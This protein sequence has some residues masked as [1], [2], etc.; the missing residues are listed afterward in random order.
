MK[1]LKLI[2]ELLKLMSNPIIRVFFKNNYINIK[3]F[4]FILLRVDIQLLTYLV[5]IIV[6]YVSRK[7]E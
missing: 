3:L 6:Q 4:C 5:N 2:T 1:K 7:H